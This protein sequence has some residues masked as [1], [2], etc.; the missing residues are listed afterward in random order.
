MIGHSLSMGATAS[1]MSRTG[2][3]SHGHGSRGR[4]SNAVVAGARVRHVAVV[5]L[6]RPRLVHQR[7]E[8]EARWRQDYVRSERLALRWAWPWTQKA[9]QADVPAVGRFGEAH[10]P[11]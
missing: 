5:Q 8:C 7:A 6:V 10:P 4:A 3:G 11:A 2:N 1:S 9:E